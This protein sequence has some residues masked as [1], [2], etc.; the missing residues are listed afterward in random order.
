MVSHKYESSVNRS[1]WLHGRNSK[2]SYD[3]TRKRQKRCFY[4]LALVAV[5]WFLYYNYTMVKSESSR[6]KF[7]KYT[8]KER[9]KFVKYMNKERVVG[10]QSETPSIKKV[11]HTVRVGGYQSYWLNL[12]TND[13]EFKKKTRKFEY[14]KGVLYNLWSNEATATLTDIGC[15]GGEISFIA[16]HVGY[17]RI[18]C[19]D[20][21]SEYVSTV[22]RLVSMQN[23]TDVVFPR[24]F[25]FG[26][27]FNKTDVVVC[28]ALIHWVFRCTADF[29]DFNAIM[30]YLVAS[31]GKFL[32]IEW[33]HPLDPGCS[34]WK[35][36]ECNLKPTKEAYSVQNFERALSRYGSIILKDPVDGPTRVMY[37]LKIT[38]SDVNSSLIS[39]GAKKIVKSLENS[40]IGLK[41][42]EHEVCIL[43]LLQKFPW[44]PQLLSTSKDGVMMSDVGKQVTKETLP[45]NYKEQL[46]Q[47]LD[48]M[49]SVGVRHNLLITKDN[50]NLME[51]NGTLSVKNFLA[52]TVNESSNCEFEGTPANLDT[53]DDSKVVERLEEKLGI[54]FVKYLN[55]KRKVGSQAENPTIDSDGSTV[56]VNGYQNYWLDLENDTMTFKKKVGKFQYIQSLLRDLYQDH[57]ATTLTDIGCSGGE[58]SFIAQHLGYKRVDCLDH[59]SEYVSTVEKLIDMQHLT[60]VVY[61]KVFSFGE[62]FRKSDV[63]VC[64]AIIH[65]V[66]S[67]TADFGDFN[68]I[69][70]Y[71]VDSVGKF[72]LIEWIDPRDNAIT[73]F[74]HLNCNS[75]PTKEVYNVQNFE[76]ALSAHGKIIS[77]RAVEGDTRVMYL[78]HLETGK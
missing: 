20:H 65:W 46:K 22:K 69:I 41:T 15:S 39:P 13:M 28:G 19:L 51:K 17:K 61:P 18:I 9:T 45:S 25:S 76:R 12:Q 62:P 71:L 57:G 11:G 31:V 29:G 38:P 3:E 24:E 33:V 56:K 23:L 63:V 44:C 5:V 21:D 77:K 30:K 35:H 74:H 66:F 2:D 60:K 54:K 53:F 73:G 6:P 42:T 4:F 1:G 50:L 72:L 59:D 7:V 32:L 68:A 34:G 78:I 43:K 40:S 64:G 58:V 75:K 47:I 8:N 55:E 26:E 14:I 10:S 37:L 70:K 48:D 67:C 49:R 36:W 52:A 16:Q 27:R